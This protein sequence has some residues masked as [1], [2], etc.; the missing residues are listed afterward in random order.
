MKAAPERC[1][2]QSSTPTPAAAPP[3][4]AQPA[5]TVVHARLV[6]TPPP[7]PSTPPPAFSPLA[8]I[9]RI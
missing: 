3:A 9:L 4:L 8:V 7:A 6:S 2:L 5:A 1:W